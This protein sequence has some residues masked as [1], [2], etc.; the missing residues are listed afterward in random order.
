M[1]YRSLF[2]A[3]RVASISVGRAHAMAIGD[4]PHAPAQLPAG[5]LLRLQH[6]FAFAPL[7]GRQASRQHG[8]QV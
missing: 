5:G 6:S 1:D 4:L 2:G 7:D 8:A 3:Q